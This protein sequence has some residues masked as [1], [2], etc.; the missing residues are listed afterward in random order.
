MVQNFPVNTGDYLYVTVTYNTSSPNGTA[1]LEDQTTGQYVS[2]GYNQPPSSLGSSAA[3]AG[4]G[5]E[6][7]ME[8]PTAS[9]GTL[10]NL[11]N[12]YVPDTAY[13][14]LWLSPAYLHFP[15]YYP[16]GL[17]TSGTFNVISMYCPSG[18]WNPSYACD[19]DPYPFARL[20]LVILPD[21]AFRVRH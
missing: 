20:L 5:A 4:Y 10:Y 15:S 9:N 3:Y 11:A 1:F 17:D 16:P 2:I 14:E 19:G 13:N 18:T 8:R 21:A 6:W 7:I 12:Y